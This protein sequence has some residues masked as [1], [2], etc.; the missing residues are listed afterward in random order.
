MST[1]DL[2]VMVDLVEDETEV[3]FAE[4]ASQSGYHS[5]AFVPPPPASHCADFKLQSFM[6]PPVEPA[7][8]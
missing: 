7:K 8:D 4:P 5:I 1:S 6:A 3:E 2:G